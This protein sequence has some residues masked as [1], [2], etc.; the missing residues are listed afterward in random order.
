MRAGGGK[1]SS[2][3][4]AAATT[5]DQVLAAL[6][7]DLTTLWTLVCTFFVVSR[8]GARQQICRAGAGPARA[9]RGRHAARPL[10]RRLHPPGSS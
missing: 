9:S 7:G 1:A 3:M 6:S 5:G 4:A 2:A 8:E 10:P